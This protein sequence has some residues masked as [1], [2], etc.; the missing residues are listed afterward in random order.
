MLTINEIFYSVQGESSYAGRPCVFVR[1]TACDLRC[2]WCDTPYAF[3]EGRKRP[4]DEVLEEL[5]AYACPL[6]EVTGG[7]PLLQ[8]D[9]YPLM[10]RLLE[11]GRTVLLETGGHRS[12][13]RVPDRVV[14]ILDVKCPGSGESAKNDWS[15]LDR[16]RPQDEVKFVVKDRA[17]YE[18]ARDV[19]ARHDLATRAAAV[20]VSPVHGVMN[21]RTLSEWVLADKLPVRVQLQLH[22]YIWDPATRGV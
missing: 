20:H 9:V 1:L 4:L 14:T 21:A 7:E 16:L 6:V 11:R 13:A 10:E 12:T 17:D 3:H 22:K 19:I 5:D 18:Y 2:S 15:N 8:E